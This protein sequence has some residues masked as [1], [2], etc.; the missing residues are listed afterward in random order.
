MC[1]RLER[2]KV[3][4]K[5]YYSGFVVRAYINDDL[6]ERKNIAYTRKKEERK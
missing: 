4:A 3:V 2:E 6:Y 5:I 1:K